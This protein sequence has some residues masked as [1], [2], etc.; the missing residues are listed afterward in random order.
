MKE[1]KEFRKEREKHFENADHSFT[2]AVYG[3]P[4]HY[5]E[6]G[7]WREIDNTVELGAD[8]RYENKKNDFKVSFAGDASDEKLI[9]VAKDG[10][11]LSWKMMNALK[12]DVHPGKK[13]DTKKKKEDMEV[14]GLHAAM[15]YKNVFDGMDLEYELRSKT[16]KENIVLNK[17]LV[18]GKVVFEIA[19]DLLPETDGGRVL[20][21]TDEGEEIFVMAA[22]FMFDANGKESH[23]IEVLC[24]RKREAGKFLYTLIPNEKW[25]L[26]E[27]RKWPVTIDPVISSSMDYT[28]I[29]DVR[30]LSRYPN[31]QF[32]NDFKLIVGQD[33]SVGIARSLVN[34][35][36]PELH[37]ADMV[38]NAVLNLTCYSNY[39]QDCRVHV[40]R[41][42]ENWNEHEV[43]WNSMPQYDNKIID[44]VEFMDTTGQSV[45]FDITEVVKDW[46][47]NGNK[48]GLLL[49][50]SQEAG[51]YIEF[52][53][54]DSHEAYAELRPRMFIQYVN[55]TGIQNFW[56]Y[57][58]QDIGRA[59][60]VYVNDYNG[61]MI[62][63]R[64]LFTGSGNLMPYALE[65]VYNSNDK[66]VDIGYG[67]GFRM[68]YHQKIELKKI[69]NI[70][71]YEWIDGTGTRH[72][73][74]QDSENGKW[75]DELNNE[76]E[77]TIETVAAEKYVISS[78]KDHKLI[79]DSSGLLVQV[80]DVNGNSLTITYD[81]TP[82]ISSVTDGA[83][84]SVHMDYNEY[85]TITVTDPAG[86]NIWC[87]KHNGYL[88]GFQDYDG[89]TCSLEYEN[90]LIVRVNNFDNYSMAYEYTET[91][92][93][94]KRIKEYAGGA[95]QKTLDI[96][97]G[98]NIN[99]FK[100]DRGR[101]EYYLF[102][103]A[104][105]TVSIKN[106]EGYAQVSE[107]MK[108]GAS[109]NKL[110]QVSK[111]Q[112]TIPQL[113]KNP[114]LLDTEEW[115]ANSSSA[116]INTNSA[117]V[118]TGMKSL[119]ISCDS[120]NSTMQFYQFVRLKRGHT[121][122]FSGYVLV[123]SMGEA[124]ATG[125]AILGVGIP[126]ISGD[127]AVFTGPQ[128]LFDTQGEWRYVEYTFTIPENAFS[129][130]ALLWPTVR[131]CVGTAYFA[132]LQLEEGPIGSRRNFVENN[133]F[134]Y[135]LDKF[136]KSTTME[137]RDMLVDITELADEV[138]TVQSGLVNAD[139]LNV[140]SGPGTS[141][142]KIG[143]VIQ[144]E[145]VTILETVPGEGIE[146]HKITYGVSGVKY[147]G[148]VSAEYI[149]V[150]DDSVHMGTVNADIL[151]VRSGPGT[152]YTRILQLTYGT[153]VTI[154]G[155]ATGS[156][157]TWYHIQTL[158]NG[159][160]YDG[161][162]VTDY[163]DLIT[164]TSAGNVAVDKEEIPILS[165]NL[166]SKVFRMIGDP[167][168]EKRLSQTIEITGK[169]GDTFVISGWGAGNSVPLKENRKFGLELEFTYTDGTKEAFSANFTGDSNQW[170]Y[171]NKPVVAKKDYTSIKASYV[172]G[173]NANK[174]YFDGLSVF[175]DE[176][177]PSFTYDD[178]GN[179]V[180]CTDA[181]EKETTFGYDTNNNITK[182]TTPTGAEFE[183]A[184]D[185]KHRITSAVTA[186]GKKYTFEYDNHGNITS[187]KIVDT[188]NEANFICSK[189]V[190]T[191][192]GNYPL[193]NTDYF[194][195]EVAF[196]YNLSTGNL[197]SVTDVNGKK[198]SYTYD[199]MGKLLTVSKPNT[200]NGAETTV[201]QT[202]TYEKDRIKTIRHNDMDYVFTYDDFGNMTKVSVADRVLVTH[203]YA[204][205]GTQLEKSVYGNGQ[206]VHYEYD[207]FDRV[208]RKT[209]KDGN[210]NTLQDLKYIYDH[211][212]N[213]A[214]VGDYSGI[215]PVN[216][217]HYSLS[218]K[219]AMEDDT[220]DN[221]TKYTYDTE[222]RLT[223]VENKSL[224]VIRTSRY[225]YDADDREVQTTTIGGKHLNTEYDSLGRIIGQTLDTTTPFE[226]I[227]A[228]RAAADG[229][230]TPVVESMN[231]G[232]KN[233]AIQYHDDGN[234][235]QIT[236][237]KGIVSYEYDSLGQLL[238]VNDAFNNKTYIYVYDAGFNMT[239][240]KIYAY[241]TAETPTGNPTS[242]RVFSYD[243]TW[244]DQMVSCDGKVMSYDGMGNLTSFD[245]VT[246]T[247]SKGRK[248]AKVTKADGKE[249]M[250]EYDE[251]GRRTLKS[252]TDIHE[253][254]SYIGNK[255]FRKI[256]YEIE[257]FFSY[258]VLGNPV[259]VMY[260]DV[261]YYYVK[262]IQ[263]DI[264]GLVDG[265]GTWVVEY[266]YDAW[267]R[268]L[269]VTG[270][271][272][273]T[274]GQDNPLRYR[275]YFYDA[276]T[277]FYYVSSRYYDPEIGRFISADGAISGVGGD[278]R[279]YNLYS[280][281]FNNPVNMSDPDGN[282]PKW[283][284]KIGNAVKNTVKTVVKAVKKAAN[285]V[286]TTVAKFAK[287][288][289][290]AS[291]KRP[292]TGE[293][294]STYVAPNGDR[295]T[296]GPD[297]KPV[298]D[299]DHSDHGNPKNHPHDENGGHHHD[300]DWTKNPPRQGAYVPNVEM[301]VG[302][303][304]VTVSSIGIAAVALD[305]L[306]GIGIADNFL[307]GP[308]GAG[309]SQGLIMIY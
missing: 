150:F 244:K 191:S 5:M 284:S 302:V 24:E 113:A 216:R 247:W 44:F 89:K 148:Y 236:T 2:A 168:K 53:S 80:K 205:K 187:H 250:Y 61:N 30:L 173:H 290:G 235:K 140:R 87:N 238:R 265:N 97:Y 139:L 21:K 248:L 95:V 209:E 193:N 217:Y 234:I 73:F 57:H 211:E 143:E 195:K 124:Y 249:I 136:T 162:A 301:I 37:P 39:M 25:L 7:E 34:F 255:L 33:V 262:N 167:S 56:T 206:S 85:G 252:S 178:D 219:L 294:G 132:D 116:V 149:V 228:Y 19:T 101:C 123:E 70:S 36:L 239:S 305:D 88:N 17:P 104:G 119:K 107:Y 163:I 54:A 256:T 78:K 295:R 257:M 152:D 100:D 93:R 26:S 66:D 297:G 126:A 285:T 309:V 175:K 69:E 76:L 242:Q 67:K 41:V 201:T 251:L 170:Q 131:K 230:A 145:V 142:S 137:D 158:Y 241:T 127:R 260:N 47:T 165:G 13:P 118:R 18:E 4:V 280:Y 291:N 298:H 154:L 184:Y 246:Y 289:S 263:G 112:R 212:G 199:E 218:G 117:Y 86:R 77:L 254:Y 114:Y 16:L 223:A 267:G 84:R 83:G 68:N 133:D 43:T 125:G 135:E 105:R 22:P 192:D 293:P 60:Q 8:G 1:R 91:P 300:W 275:G 72:Y 110:S 122:T 245:G 151:N 153:T 259:A 147:E 106:D 210:G 156:G 42:L 207:V 174:A 169:A 103:N 282:W 49:K 38:I 279:G 98:F 271:L 197:D 190:Y 74:K 6:N 9:T 64:S 58:T 182:I 308:L 45:Q 243:S 59:G 141:Y 50:D 28:K 221:F 52:L 81:T 130:D 159:S 128:G 157:Y 46:Y 138:P 161:Y 225:G 186:T 177:W 31:S 29:Y 75:M 269:S 90:G 109:V 188:E 12:A 15:A 264:I 71:Y 232:G 35:D 303:G 266:D 258:D 111:L 307:Y 200:I 220:Y 82:K 277:G 180:S 79:F 231:N 268:P 296:Y 202:Y 229:S 306:T 287:K 288:T 96:E 121:Y 270:T 65:F 164:A 3:Q 171:V 155:T 281:C 233:I 20:F 48:H 10:H 304:L 146:W 144:G 276:E 261:E 40:H 185:D 160:I 240:E 179:V 92:T 120:L 183:Y 292:P 189:Y 224:D 194:G 204:M 198:T 227:F 283:V 181:R 115:I 176:Y 108:D 51:T 214:L 99:K 222:D 253:G 196:E 278:I 226:T 215:G 14:T 102:D 134:T 11:S 27:E 208:I 63:R 237:D 272:A 274:L 273:D 299:Y 166:S 32:G 62:Y 23:A 213:L 286:K 172:Y 94:V 55:Y 129:E 203:T